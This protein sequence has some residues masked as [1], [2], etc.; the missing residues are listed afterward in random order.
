LFRSNR[1]GVTEYQA[2]LGGVNGLPFGEHRIV[3]TNLSTD[4]RQPVLDIDAFV[5]EM[6]TGNR[7]GETFAGLAVIDDADPRAGITYSANG[8]A[9]TSLVALRI[10]SGQVGR[11]MKLG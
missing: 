4:Q 8:W 7:G 10:H 5:V 3:V 1:K 2:L 11:S 6:V 9:T